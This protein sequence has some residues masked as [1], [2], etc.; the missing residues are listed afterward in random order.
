MVKLK[1]TTNSKEGKIR[2]MTGSSTEEVLYTIKAFEN[3]A[4]DIDLPNNQ[5][6]KEFMN[7]LRSKARDRWVKLVK[8]RRSGD[9]ASNQWNQAKKEW[10]VEYVKR[11]RKPKKQS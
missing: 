9:F 11:I 2:L 4:I 8:N 3:K 1:N 6:I 10:I 5:R 7:C